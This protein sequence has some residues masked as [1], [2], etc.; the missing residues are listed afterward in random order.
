M[1]VLE[2][3][4]RKMLMGPQPKGAGDQRCGHDPEQEEPPG[5][6]GQPMEIP[7]LFLRKVALS[8]EHHRGPASQGS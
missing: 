2:G 6:F 7:G 3:Q 8:G 1:Q 4:G 5:V